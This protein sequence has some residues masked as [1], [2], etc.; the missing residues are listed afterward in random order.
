RPA[1]PAPDQYCPPHRV[2][3]APPPRTILCPYTSLSRSSSRSACGRLPAA[4]TALATRASTPGCSRSAR[5]ID[6][7]APWRSRCSPVVTPRSEEYTSELQSRENLV[8]RLL[9]EKKKK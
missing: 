8:C 7:P 5:S 2:L 1:V 3:A 4:T 9:L 6:P